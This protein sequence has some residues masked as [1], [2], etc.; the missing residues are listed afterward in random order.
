MI[1]GVGSG[2]QCP[3]PWIFKHGTN[4]VD[5]GLKV[6]FFG[7]FWLFSVF[8]S[9]PSPLP[10]KRLNSAIF[11]YF[12]L[13]SLLPPPSFLKN[14]LPTHLPFN[15]KIKQRSCENHFLRLL[16]MANTWIIRKE[17]LCI[18]EFRSFGHV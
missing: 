18:S 4:I 13:I 9:V 14:F 5:R 16:L 12:L 11:R 17:Q 8:F 3:P 2:G 6:L 15:A 1:M 7:L 10:W